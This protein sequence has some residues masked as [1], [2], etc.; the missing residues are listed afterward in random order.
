[1]S[2][3]YEL[4]MEGQKVIVVDR[5]AIAGGIT[6]LTS[7]HLAPLC[8]VLTSAIIKLRGEDI[9]RAFYVSQ[10]AAV[11][12]IEQIQQLEKIACDFRRLDG[13][14]FQALDTDPAIIDEELDAVRK[15]GAPVHRIVGVEALARCEEQHTLRYP[16][17]ATFHPLKY[18]AGLA[19]AIK[20]KGGLLCAGTTVQTVEERG[21]EVV[22]KTDRGSLTGTAAVV[23]TNSPVVDAV[24]LHTKMAPYRT[25]AMATRIRRGTLPDAL[26]WDTL[27]PYHYVRVQPGDRQT[28]FV[29]VGGADHKTGEANDA[30]VRFEALEASAR[31]LIPKL[32]E[33]S[34]RWSGQVLDT[35]DYA[36]FIGRNPGHER[37][38]VHTG[39]SGQGMTH[40]VVG[41]LLNSALIL[42][43][44]EVGRCL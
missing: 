30:G 44:G 9:S 7:A 36:A 24:A 22:V 38:Y 19:R 28:D 17:Q 41:S 15:V 43:R 6:A 13:F 27:D 40:G 42:Q 35:I 8:D 32:D 31:N 14:L 23:A 3:A 33:V 34:H 37:V 1:M 20:A 5:G 2:T 26:Y 25:Y 18:L 4:A 21:G 39:D 11:D 10:A 29:I 12:R 16:R